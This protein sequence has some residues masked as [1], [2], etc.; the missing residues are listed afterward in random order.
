MLR[1]AADFL[2]GM[3]SGLFL[4]AA[5]AAFW[6]VTADAPGRPT[7]PS[8]T[9][10]ETR[11]MRE[12]RAARA[13]PRGDYAL[14]RIRPPAG[15]RASRGG[16]AALSAAPARRRA[17]PD[18][19]ELRYR[20]L[21]PRRARAGGAAPALVLLSGRAGALDDWVRVAERAGL[22]LLMPEAADWPGAAAAPGA[23]E[24]ILADA[25]RAAAIDRARLYLHGEDGADGA[26]LALANRAPG[27]WRAVSARGTGFDAGPVRRTGARMPPAALFATG[28][29]AAPAAAHAAAAGL[30]AAGHPVTLVE[31]A[32]TGAP[33]RWLAGRAW[34]FLRSR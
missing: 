19:A 24:R 10:V 30:S 22:V 23:V 27:L 9:G 34:A 17:G 26:A 33:G 2:S 16:T 7:T 14:R 5:A 29:G 28:A 1:A 3:S 15:A 31:V 4:M 12:A 18:G 11:A 21:V 25:G 8:D 6:A 20:L 32:G 13:A